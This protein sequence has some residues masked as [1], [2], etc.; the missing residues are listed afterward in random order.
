MFVI[1]NGDTGILVQAR[2]VESE[3]DLSE[4]IRD[5][6]KLTG[7]PQDQVTVNEVLPPVTVELDR[8]PL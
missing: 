3:N 1:S 4:A 5:F 2:F 6:I 8:I 7:T